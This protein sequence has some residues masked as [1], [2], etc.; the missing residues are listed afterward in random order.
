M[1]RSRGGPATREAQMT[2][3]A[4]LLG[5]SI[6]CACTLLAQ[7]SRAQSAPDKVAPPDAQASN[8]DQPDDIIVTARKRA[9]RL[10]D[11]P[12]SVAALSGDRLEKQ[13][14]TSLAQYAGYVPSLN[15]ETLGNPGETRLTLR[16]I[17]PIGSGAVVGSYLDDIPL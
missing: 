12:S 9:E 2:K 10:Q 6:M 14:A 1:S 8:N 13:G 17:A 7:P 11:V 15:V 5:C 4:S 3:K 16:G